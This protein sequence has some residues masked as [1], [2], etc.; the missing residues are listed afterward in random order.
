MECL[1]QV[2]QTV[3]KCF[4]H[5]QDDACISLDNCMY[6]TRV[7]HCCR[8]IANRESARRVRQK[9]QDVMEDLQVKVST[10]AVLRLLYRPRHDICDATVILMVA[11][12]AAPGALPGGHHAERLEQ[13]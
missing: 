7:E 13:G 8:R 4:M 6:E 3:L 11:V 1:N 12:C 10:H 5:L 9:R 2:L